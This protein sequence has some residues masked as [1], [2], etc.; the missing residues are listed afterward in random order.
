MSTLII[1]QTPNQYI[2]E[3][4]NR[5]NEEEIAVLKRRLELINK[6]D[7]E[8]LNCLFEQTLVNNKQSDKGGAGVGLIGIAKKSFKKSVFQFYQLESNCHMFSLT[9]AIDRFYKSKN[10]PHNEQK[11]K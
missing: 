3:I 2:I 9:A 7:N 8:G 10:T 4:S 1:K 6:L 11:A 5:I